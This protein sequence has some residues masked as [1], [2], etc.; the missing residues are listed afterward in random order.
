MGHTGQYPPATHAVTTLGFK[1]DED[2]GVPVFRNAAFI[3][4]LKDKNLYDESVIILAGDH[5][6]MNGRWGLIDKGVYLYPD[7]LRTPMIVKM[8]SSANIRPQSIDAPVSLLDI[9]PTLLSV[10]GIEPDAWLD[11]QSL[12]PLMQGKTPPT[13][14]D[15][16]FS[17]GW[18]VGVNF[19]CGVQHWDGKG[20][21]HLYAYNTSS[22]VD[23]LYDL[24]AAEAENLAQDPQY[25]KLRR[26]MIERLGT[27]LRADSRW[28]GY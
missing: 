27:L 23:E 19:A 18:H 2:G 12:I 21:H 28:E 7:V 4:A 22:N 14:R 13:D 9:A 17:C 3:Q 24:N 11:G 20:N 8:P 16:I 6:E 25:A 10:A 15:M 26:Q 1:W 5:G